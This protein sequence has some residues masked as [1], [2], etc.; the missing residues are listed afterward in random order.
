MTEVG[1]KTKLKEPTEMKKLLPL[2]KWATLIQATASLAAEST[3]AGKTFAFESRDGAVVISHGGQRVGEYVYRDD[4]I[5]RP[6]FANLSAPGGVQVTRNH[7]PQAGKDQTDHATFHPGVWLAFGDLSGQDSWRNLAPIRH[8][9]FTEPPGVRDGKLTFATESRMLTTNSQPLCTL[10][11]RVT[12]AARPA[13]YLLIWDATFQA[14]EQDLAFGDQEEMGLGVR[15]ATPITEKNGGLITSSTGGKTA[16]ATWGKPFDWCDYSGLI[17]DRRVGVALMPDP[18][19]FR[20][21]WFH[22]RDYGLMVANPFGRNAMKQGEVSRVEVK[23]G[24]K[25]RLRF[26]ILLH[27]TP[28]ERDADLAAAYR[29]FLGQSPKPTP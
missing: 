9:R 29:D 2:I 15:V 3:P 27:S 6:Y 8:E 25:L 12:V 1:M 26:G 24:E 28:A 4:T 21:S 19:N 23:R 17:G 20:P 22:N 10:L 16:K 7:P 11:S 18:S 13:G 5:L 14:S